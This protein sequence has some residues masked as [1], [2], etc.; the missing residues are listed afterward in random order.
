MYCHNNE[1]IIIVL[2]WKASSSEDLFSQQ[3]FSDKERIKTLLTLLIFPLA[4]FQQMLFQRPY[5]K[6]K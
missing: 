1:P 4:H 3:T 6:R 5:L 2:I